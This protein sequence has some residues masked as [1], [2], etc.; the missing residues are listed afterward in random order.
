M[1]S[2]AAGM[3]T[4]LKPQIGHNIGSRAQSAP[5]QHGYG[6]EV[7]HS[8]R[9]VWGR[10]VWGGTEPRNARPM[11]QND[12]GVAVRERLAARERLVGN[13]AR[14]IRGQLL[15]EVDD[16]RLVVQKLP[17]QHPQQDGT[18]VEPGGGGRE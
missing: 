11:V 8:T 3:S 10:R 16:P 18:E 14:L 1:V 17:D 4:R 5:S 6:Y 15:H 12:V 7:E 13:L 2:T 9:R